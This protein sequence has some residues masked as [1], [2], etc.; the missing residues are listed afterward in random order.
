M[1][2]Q[3]NAGTPAAHYATLQGRVALVTGASKGIGAE[4]A[5]QLASAGAK[6]VVNY[7]SSKAGGDA[8]VTAIT[9]AGGQAIAVQGDFSK[10]ADVTRV[11]AEATKAFGRVDVLV[12]N[13]GVY[14]FAALESI[15]NE[16][17]RRQYDLNVT[18]LILASK[19]AAAQFGDAGGNI[20]NISSSITRFLP[21]QATVYASTKAAVDAITVTLA[22]ELGPK[23]VRVNAVNPGMIVT[24][25]TA[26]AGF[27]DPE[28]PLAQQI[29]AST[30]LGRLGNV[31]D[32]AP[33]VTFL[34]SDA[35]RWISGETISVAGGFR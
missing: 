27:S 8:V 11:F 17:I 6:V 21:P 20:I 33:V 1:A 4:I 2:T 22:K 31:G 19:A 26:T 25:G 9:A 18:G 10:E 14:E 13:A 15:T 12:N 32:I 34:A 30:P 29:L 7:A 24:E 28:A 23:G 35:S 16:H 3:T 5:K